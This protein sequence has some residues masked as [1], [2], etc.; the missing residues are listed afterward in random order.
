MSLARGVSLIGAGT[1]RFHHRIH[2]DKSGRELFIEAAREAIESVDKGI[3]RRDLQAVFVGYFTPE[4]YEHQGHIGAQIADWLGLCPIPAWR[5]ESACASSAYAFMT[6]VLAIASGIYDVVLVGGVEKMTE[7]TTEQV[8]DALSMAGCDD[9][10]LPPGATFPGLYALMAQAYFKKYGATWEQLQAVPIKNHHNGTLN[11]NAQYQEEIIDIGERWGARQGLSFKDSMEFLKSPLNRMVAYPLRLFDCCPISDG[12]AAAI[13]AA[14]DV[15]KKYTDTPIKVT[16]I[17]AST[18]TLALHDRPS[19][20]SLRATV[21]AGKQAYNMAGIKPKDVDVAVVHDCFTIAEILAIED[22]GFF[23]R[24]KGIKAVEE[25]R[26]ALDGDIPINTDGG[27][28]CKGHPVGAT[29]VGMAH[30]IWKQLRGEAG[31]RQVADAKMGL[32]HNIGG[33]GPSCV[34]A[35]LSR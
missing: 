32:L 26:T 30:E 9:Y 23:K 6:G 15:A 13:L 11:P 1:T 8:T 17:S 18:D 4:S 5:T 34:V 21:E 10:E 16:G 14:E 22:L 12:A 7:L 28:K 2:R 24:G 31:K 35:I 29:G 20:T 33:S 19:L 3:K 27:L 25:G